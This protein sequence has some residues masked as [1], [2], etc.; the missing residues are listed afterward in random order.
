MGSMNNDPGWA[1][2]PIAII[3]LSCKFAGD[4]SNPEKLWDML[5]EGRSAWSEV[6]ASRY[7]HKGQYHPENGKLSAV[8][9][10]GEIVLS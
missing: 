5:A 8:G 10:H 7:G 1:T 4:A 3:G 6:P 9:C 2:E